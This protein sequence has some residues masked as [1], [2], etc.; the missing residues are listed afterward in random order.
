MSHTSTRRTLL[1]HQRR[2]ADDANIAIDGRGYVAS[3]TANLWRSLSLPAKAS[4]DL[5][6]GSELRDGKTRPAKMRALLS[7]SALAV[8]VFDYWSVRDSTPMLEALETGPAIAPP[9]FEA[10]FPTG[11]KGEPPNLDVAIRLASGITLAIESKYCEWLTPNSNSEPP[12]KAKYFAPVPDLWRRAG[13]P[14]CQGLAD[15]VQGKAER[16]V[17]LDVPQ[18][19]KHALGL[20]TN[21]KEHFSLCYLYYDWPCPESETHQLEVDRFSSRVGRELRFRAITYQTLFR[22]LSQKCGVRDDEY[23]AYLRSRYFTTAA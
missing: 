20:A 8:N 2:W 18:L 17:H 12:F 6:G 13:L 19:L 15:D 9:H 1:E 21:L 7:S 10:K 11:L 14:E 3:Y 22:R 16:F 4:F 5:G 23:I